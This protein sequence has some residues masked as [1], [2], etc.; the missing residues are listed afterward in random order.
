M[1][2][3]MPANYD[4]DRAEEIIRYDLYFNAA[5]NIQQDLLNQLGWSPSPATWAGTA[6]D[7]HQVADVILWDRTYGNPGG[8][9]QDL[10]A[11]LGWQTENP[12]ENEAQP[13]PPAVADYQLD[14]QAYIDAVLNTY[15]LGGLSSK[16]WE[17]IVNGTA[18]SP[19]RLIQ[20]L[21]DQQEYKDRFKGMAIRQS[22]GLAAISEGE[23]ISYERQAFQL[24]RDAG[25]PPE[26]W[27]QHDDFANLIGADLSINELNS[28]IAN[29]FLKVTRAPQEVR[30]AFSY[31]YGASGDAALASIF[32][33]ADQAG[34][35]LEKMANA[36]EIG[37]YGRTFSF[38][39]TKDT[40]EGLSVRNVSADEAQRGFAQ[41]DLERGY[42][43]E[44]ITEG[45][46]LTAE[47]EGVGA[48]FQTDDESAAKVRKRK[49]QREA[50]FSGSPG[51]G[52]VTPQGA[53]GLGSS[54]R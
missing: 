37:G 54:R 49:E 26:F 47:N 31:F 45:L 35:A 22:K 17:Q 30:D 41:L 24:M 16:A 36:A 20:W 9:L 21:R 10:Q 5:G 51:A 7:W 6:E 52:G 29:G 3:T 48:T 32:L 11:Q 33:D 46:D 28:R 25:M 42:Y 27:D 12:P 1:A 53:V 38:D 8:T 2:D 44:T 50:A 43:D 34:V 19:E 39:I 15:D 4:W 23:Y 18:D 40:A 14:A 13:Q